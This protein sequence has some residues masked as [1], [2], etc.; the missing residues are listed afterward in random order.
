L[1]LNRTVWMWRKFH[2][3]ARC[4]THFCSVGSLWIVHNIMELWNMLYI[5]PFELLQTLPDCHNG[6]IIL[7]RFLKWRPG[8]VAT[9][10]CF[11][12]TLHNFF[13]FWECTQY[14]FV[15]LIIIFWYLN[16]S[17]LMSKQ[18]EDFSFSYVWSSGISLT[19][20]KLSE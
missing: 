4:C 17:C 2:H 3:V 9:S 13:L 7:S 5:I 15:C 10:K 14:H 20:V 16:I 18:Q 12:Y 11:F 6:N 19:F 8:T 1:W